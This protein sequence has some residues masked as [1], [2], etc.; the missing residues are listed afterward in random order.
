MVLV[1]SSSRRLA[2]RQAAISATRPSFTRLASPTCGRRKV[3]TSKCDSTRQTRRA[4]A[5]KAKGLPRGMSINSTTG[6]ISGQPQ[7]DQAGSHPVQ[8]TATSKRHTHSVSLNWIVR[9]ANR[10]E[11]IDEQY[12]RVGEPLKVRLLAHDAIGNSLTYRF[13]GLPPG[14]TFDE[15]VGFV[16]KV[17]SGREGKYK[18]TAS[19]TGGNGTD[20]TTF[21]W[22]V[23]AE[24]RAARGICDQR[25]VH[26]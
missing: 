18:V 15:K 26:S 17:K 11:W 1:P 21:Q 10:W 4:L 19:V 8:L 25:H 9:D 23:F 2:R 14:V 6:V 3:R 22:T 13:D 20:T 12:D 5:W 24:S 7:Y 16:G